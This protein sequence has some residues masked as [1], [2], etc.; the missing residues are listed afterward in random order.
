MLLNTARGPLIDEE[1][2]AQALNAGKLR[3][4]A[5]DVVCQEPILED[6]PLLTCK[7]CILTP[8]IAWA[9]IE[10]RQRLLNTVIKNIRGFLEGKPRNVVNM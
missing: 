3:G 10:S 8:H 9:P 7:N 1:A 4:A 6:S 2:L 5:L